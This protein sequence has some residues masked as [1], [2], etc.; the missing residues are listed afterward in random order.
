[1]TRFPRKVATRLQ[2]LAYPTVA[3]RGALAARADAGTRFAR[4]FA[5]P[6]RTH[7]DTRRRELAQE[8]LRLAVTLIGQQGIAALERAIAPRGAAR[9]DT[10]AV[11]AALAVAE[12]LART[13]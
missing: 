1:M 10:E 5:S 6:G 9:R 2:R 7:A 13:P 8:N 11:R 12:A 4:A 3:A